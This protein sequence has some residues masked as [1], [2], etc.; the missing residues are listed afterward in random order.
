MNKKDSYFNILQNTIED[1]L[2]YYTSYLET[3]DKDSWD[4]FMCNTLMLGTIF[5]EVKEKTNIDISSINLN[6][7]DKINKC[8]DFNPKNRLKNKDNILKHLND[9]NNEI[10]LLEKEYSKFNII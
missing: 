8:A 5:L 3:G 2:K 7:F 1:T 10:L 9:L 6:I 4:I